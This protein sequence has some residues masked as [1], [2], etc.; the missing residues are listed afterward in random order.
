MTSIILSVEECSSLLLLRLQLRAM[1]VSGMAVSGKRQ[2]ARALVPVP[3]PASR[4]GSRRSTDRAA[5]DRSADR[6]R[7]S[8]RRARAAG[9]GG[10]RSRLGRSRAR[11]PDGHCGRFERNIVVYGISVYVRLYIGG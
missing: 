11:I 1:A 7:R 8:P 5:P 9:R 10:P 3:K 2:D 6:A 4:R